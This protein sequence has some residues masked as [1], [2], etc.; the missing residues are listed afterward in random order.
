MF[1][2]IVC[3]VDGSDHARKAAVMASELAANAGAKLT[4]LTVTKEIKVTDEIKR[5]MELEHLT[6]SP[7]Y[8]VDEMTDKV[9]EDAKDCAISSGVKDPRTEV[10]TGNP[11]RVIVT[12]A[13]REGADVIILGGRGHGDIGGTLLGSVSHK[14]NSLAKCTCITVK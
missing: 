14:V 4:F 12:Y 10:K 11:A 5:Y 3:A 6:G 9:L 2:N 13:E 8:V 7:Q 1:K